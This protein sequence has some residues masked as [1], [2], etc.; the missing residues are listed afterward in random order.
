MDEGIKNLL[1]A[2]HIERINKITDEMFI[3]PVVI[4]VKKDR[5]VKNALV[6]RSLNNAIVKENYQMPN[7]ESLNENVAENINGKQ[8]ADVLFTSLDMLYAHGQT[9]L[10][11]ETAKHCTF[12]I[13]E[14]ETTGTYA[15]KTFYYGLTTMPPGFQKMMDKILHKT[16]NTVF[17]RRHIG[18][19]ERNARRAHRDSIGNNQSNRRS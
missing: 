6:A 9:V 19:N 16:K 17:F 12:Q 5:S 11:P 2:G 13:I 10:H 4:I 18:A 7:L 1:A 15:F 14:G 3:Q 8:E